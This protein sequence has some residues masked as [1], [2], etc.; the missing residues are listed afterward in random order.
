MWE[1]KS[2]ISTR[3]NSAVGWLCCSIVFG[4]LLAVSVS[5]AK[6]SPSVG[7]FCIDATVD[8]NKVLEQVTGFLDEKF[9]DSNK[10]HSRGDEYVFF[11]GNDCSQNLVG[12]LW[13]TDHGR[14]SINVKQPSWWKNDE[15]RSVL[16]QHAAAGEKL[17]VFD[18]PDGHQS[19]DWTEILI[20][21]DIE[22][23]C[24]TTFEAS[25]EDDY[26]KMY[27]KRHNGLDGKIS[28]VE[29]DRESGFDVTT[30]PL[31]RYMDYRVDFCEYWGTQCGWAVAD[32]WCQLNGYQRATT[33]LA[34][35]NIG[36][37]DPTWVIG[38]Q[39]RCDQDF[40]GGFAEIT[41]LNP[42]N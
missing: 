36:T 5:E 26:I 13:T 42:A 11:E 27:Y 19:D 32:R 39:R 21:R 34:E 7:G 37:I 6:E 1:G 4:A 38:E 31:P 25:Y 40:C 33:W 29:N 35:P 18:H 17:R 14:A 12:S 10:Y 2:M 30:F 22:V 23:Y 20:K 15:A 28:R 8:V 16:I 9:R 24:V 41:C 3:R